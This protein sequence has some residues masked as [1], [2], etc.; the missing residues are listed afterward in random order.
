MAV[1]QKF[2]GS[3]LF[4]DVAGDTT[5]DTYMERMETP[6]GTVVNSVDVLGIQGQRTIAFRHALP[7]LQSVDTGGT[8]TFAAGSVAR[9]AT[10]T[11]ADKTG[12]ILTTTTIPYLLLVIMNESANKL[13]FAAIG[14]SNVQG[15]T[16]VAIS[17]GTTC[18]FLWNPNINTTGAWQP[19]P[20]AG[21]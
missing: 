15:G 12:I 8:I 21:S 20:A 17:A 13:T 10:A 11:G 9:V 5:V 19:I 7:Q 4:A 14:T 6:V 18:L 16:G 3:N 1:W 2:V